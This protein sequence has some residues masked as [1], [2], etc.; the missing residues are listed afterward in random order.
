MINKSENRIGKPPVP[1]D[2][3]LIMNPEQLLIYRG[4]QSFGWHLEFVRRPL[5]Q[6]PVFVMKHPECDDVAV[7]E[8]SGEFNRN[9]GIQLR[10]NAAQAA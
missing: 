2:V 10:E 8:E 3:H 9:H 6:R 4:M 7:I 1:D 5:F